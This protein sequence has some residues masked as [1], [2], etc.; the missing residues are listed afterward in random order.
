MR[1]GILALC[2]Q[3]EMYIRALGEY[4][5][6]G[7]L[8]MDTEVFTR[9]DK[10]RSFFE[11]GQVT[12]ILVD[13][14]LAGELDFAPEEAVMILGR[15]GQDTLAETISG[16]RYPVIGKYQAADRILSRVAVWIG[17]SPVDMHRSEA[18]GVAESPGAFAPTRQPAWYGTSRARVRAICSPISRCGKTTFAVALGEV[19]GETKNA[20]YL[21]MEEYSSFGE[22]G[23]QDQEGTLTDLLYYA[24]QRDE[25]L[26]FKLSGA[27]RTWKNLDYVPP[28]F[29]GADLRTVESSE[30]E[31]FLGRLG[32][33]SDYEEILLDIGASMMEVPGLLELCDRIY[34][35]VLEDVLSQD[36]LF[37]FTELMKAQNRAGL[38]QRMVKL[39]LPP[40]TGYEA[41][42]IDPGR[43]LRS[44]MGDYVRRL[45]QAEEEK[46]A[47]ALA[48]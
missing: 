10:L 40:M 4:L 20:L 7:R 15:A 41:A 28:S 19:L 11:T 18:A 3:D 42:G 39:H 27:V 48:E 5:G 14:R 44:P 43:L 2:D 13:E 31:Y 30:W 1:K 9:V 35:P 26:I 32:R 37:R 24:G 22:I 21:N 8:P 46:N 45:L 6:R 17:E 29:S 23:N 38:M 12:R 33:E 47:A 16:R 36:K 25:N 34:V